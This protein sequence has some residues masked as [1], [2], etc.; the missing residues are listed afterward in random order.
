VITLIGLHTLADRSVYFD[1]AQERY[2]KL[3]RNATCF[4]VPQFGL[5]TFRY[6]TEERKYGPTSGTEPEAP[7]FH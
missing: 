5:A 2:A 3:A 6:L 4:A 1:S 7:N